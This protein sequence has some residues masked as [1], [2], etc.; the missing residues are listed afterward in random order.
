M[1]RRQQDGGESSWGDEE[2]RA[3]SGKNLNQ[4]KWCGAVISG[5]GEAAHQVLLDSQPL[6]SLQTS[7]ARALFLE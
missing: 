3:V 5:E 6:N 2:V 1:D 7:V 4:Q